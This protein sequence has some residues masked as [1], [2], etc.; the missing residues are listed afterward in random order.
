M[1]R[2]N[3][4]PRASPFEKAPVSGLFLCQALSAAPNP[5]PLAFLPMA[6]SWSPEVY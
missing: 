2:V 5:V 1:T 4:A 6:V 3:D